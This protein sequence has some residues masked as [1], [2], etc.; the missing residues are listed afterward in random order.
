MRKLLS[1]LLA[2]LMPALFLCGCG[3]GDT[4][5]AN[6]PA[7]LSGGQAGGLTITD[8]TGRTVELSGPAGRIVALMPA[9]CEI[10]CALGAGGLI[11]GRGEYCQY[12]EELLGIPEVAS[13]GE[14]NI[15][16]II[17]LEP[18]VV[19][20][21][22]MAQTVEHVAALE[23]AG[24]RCVVSDAQDIEGVYS[25]IT[26]LGELTGKASRAESL[27][28][29]MRSSFDAIIS[30]SDSSGTKT[31]YFEVSPL[32]WGLWTAGRGTFMDEI[33]S[34]LGVQNAFSDVEGWAEIS[35][36]QVIERDPDYIVTVAMYLGEG[37][38]PVEEIMGREG[39]QNLKAVKNGAVLNVDSN[40]ISLPGPRLV[41]AAEALFEFFSGVSASE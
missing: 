8:M 31:V 11:V 30:K 35:E 38:T 17:A 36:E 20:M 21:S 22:K 10:L 29:D 12:P 7:G 40:E 24:I 18:D 41:N 19:V 13:G 6:N 37:E 25:A 23:K 1:L 39:W 2:L 27:V 32:E 3:T 9:D 4:K 26:M 34:L 14:T 5:D 28:A 16:Q 33:A 15:E